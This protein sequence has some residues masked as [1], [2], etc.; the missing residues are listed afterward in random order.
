M[1]L[2][3]PLYPPTPTGH[4]GAMYGTSVCGSKQGECQSSTRVVRRRET[5]MYGLQEVILQVS[6]DP[7]SDSD[8]GEA[9]QEE[10]EAS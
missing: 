5:R 4:N 9:G 2:E 1:Y 10:S 3:L 6:T 7:R 8:M